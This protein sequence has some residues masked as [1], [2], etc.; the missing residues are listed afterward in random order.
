MLTTIFNCRTGRALTY[1]IELLS[2]SVNPRQGLRST[3]DPGIRYDIPF[4]KKTM[5]NDR[6]FCTIG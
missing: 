6:N 3:S 1:L 4:N 2:E 5:F